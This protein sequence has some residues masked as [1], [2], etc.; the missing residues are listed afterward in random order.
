M[1]AQIAQTKIDCYSNNNCNNFNENNCKTQGTYK[2]ALI[3]N[4]KDKISDSSVTSEKTIIS[5]WN[6]A[7]LGTFEVRI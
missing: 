4:T 1:P 5:R 7:D 3:L 6:N 2:K